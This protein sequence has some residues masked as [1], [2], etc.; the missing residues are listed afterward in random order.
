MQ[1]MHAGRD[2]RVPRCLWKEVDVTRQ[3][4]KTPRLVS[5]TK[6]CGIK[7]IARPSTCFSDGQEVS[8][9]SKF[10]TMSPQRGADKTRIGSEEV[11]EPDD[12]AQTRK[13]TVFDAVA[14][15]RLLTAMLIRMLIHISGRAG[16]E[17]FVPPLDRKSKYRDTQSNSRQAIPPEEVLFRRKGAPIR[18]EENDIYF[19]NERLGSDQMLPDSELL[20][21]LHSYASSFYR[22]A[23]STGG[24]RDWKSMDETALLALG[25]LIEE[26][27]Q[28]HLGESGDLAFVE[29]E[30]E[31]SLT[32]HR[33]Y[34][35]GER[36]VRSV[37]SKNPTRYTDV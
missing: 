2:L 20:K 33:Q 24:K 36:W 9:N 31:D 15:K 19:A 10:S 32:G 8:S 23:T 35:D 29:D 4:K 34:W 16:Y 11:E 18:Y 1:D 22:N 13:A 26:A 14:G 17:S 12:K 3:Q 37:V 6:I 7:L 5:A 27:A 30:G 21:H 28:E 25:I